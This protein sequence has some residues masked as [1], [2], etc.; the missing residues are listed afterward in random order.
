M[1]FRSETG[2][3]F[4]LIFT[5]S[6]VNNFPPYCA[7]GKNLRLH[8]F[9]A[10]TTTIIMLIETNR[11]PEETASR[12]RRAGGAESAEPAGRRRGR[13][14][15]RAGRLGPEESSSSCGCRGGGAEGARR[16]PERGAG[17]GWRAECPAA[18]AEQRLVLERHQLTLL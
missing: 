3:H 12:R 8:I 14:E 18:P 2:K 6:P 16:L 10:Y 1:I 11:L 13:P 7:A 15:G 4:H 9:K 5:G 17:G